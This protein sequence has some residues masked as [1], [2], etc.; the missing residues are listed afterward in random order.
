MIAVVLALAAF[1]YVG[2]FWARRLD[3]F[4]EYHIAHGPASGCPDCE[5]K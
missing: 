5:G 2:I 4:D 3:R 1:A